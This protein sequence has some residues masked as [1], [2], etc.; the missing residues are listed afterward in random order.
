MG[1]PYDVTV[2][3]LDH[4]RE[5]VFSYAGQIVYA[6]DVVTIARCP[7]PSQKTVPVGPVELG[8]GDIFVEFY[9]PGEWFNIFQVHDALGVIK[10]WYANVTAPVEIDH[11][12]IRWRDLALDLLVLPGGRQMVL[13]RDE[14]QALPLDDQVRRRAQEGLR[15]LQ[16]WASEGH[17][18]FRKP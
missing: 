10:G 18:P 7:W 3:K 5:R 16:R 8:P 12:E 2:V 4:T 11:G 15:T 14:F 1:I 17:Y 9:Y 6:D 13:D